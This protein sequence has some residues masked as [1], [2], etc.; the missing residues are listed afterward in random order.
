MVSM[1]ITDVLLKYTKKRTKY[2]WDR[3][4]GCIYEN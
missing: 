2:C 1:K 4:S 3:V